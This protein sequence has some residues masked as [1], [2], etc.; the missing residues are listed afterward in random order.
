MYVLSSWLI[1]LHNLLGQLESGTPSPAAKQS[2]TVNKQTTPTKCRTGRTTQAAAS[3]DVKELCKELYNSV[4]DYT[5]CNLHCFFSF[6]I[7]SLFSSVPVTHKQ[8][9]L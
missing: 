7:F 3:S 9:R 4:K 1:V 6:N 8:M 5:V 2:T